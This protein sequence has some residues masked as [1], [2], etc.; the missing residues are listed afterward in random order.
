MGARQA[1]VG[2]EAVVNHN[3]AAKAFGHLAAFGAE[4]I[5]GESVGRD[6]RKIRLSI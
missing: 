3:V 6:C 1:S 2:L 5:E 4:A